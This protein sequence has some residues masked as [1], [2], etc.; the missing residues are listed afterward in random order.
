MP[1]N[2]T[3][4]CVP[5]FSFDFPASSFDI[6]DSR[7]VAS[8]NEHEIGQSGQNFCRTLYLSWDLGD[9]GPGFLA[10]AYVWT[11]HNDACRH[12]P[13]SLK[14]ISTAPAAVALRPAARC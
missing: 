7:F 3:S 1:N 10:K 5:F 6:I 12:R 8:A 11:S 9:P 4:M 2:L 14:K 13:G